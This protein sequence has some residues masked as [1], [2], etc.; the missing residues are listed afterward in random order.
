MTVTVI[1]EEVRTSPPQPTQFLIGGAG[2]GQT[3]GGGSIS[4]GR[5]ESV[6]PLLK[7]N[8]ESWLNIPVCLVKAMK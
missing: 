2:G 3:S 6:H 7:I 1:D 8:P 4:L 5:D